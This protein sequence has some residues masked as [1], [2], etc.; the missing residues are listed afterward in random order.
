MSKCYEHNTETGDFIRYF[1]VKIS[2]NIRPDVELGRLL[3]RA[4]PNKLSLTHVYPEMVG[5]HPGTNVI[6]HAVTVGNWAQHKA[7]PDGDRSTSRQRKND[8]PIHVSE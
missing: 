6:R 5:E 8:Q 1:N 3:R 4:Q 7:G 2:Q